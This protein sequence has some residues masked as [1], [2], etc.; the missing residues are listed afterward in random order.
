MAF[1]EPRTGEVS[2]QGRQLLSEDPSLMSYAQLQNDNHKSCFASTIPIPENSFSFIRGNTHTHIYIFTYM[3]ILVYT[4]TCICVCL[5]IG[6]MH[7]Y[8]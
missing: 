7:V 8:V 5:Y 3:Y 6:I 1:L 4:C 2:V